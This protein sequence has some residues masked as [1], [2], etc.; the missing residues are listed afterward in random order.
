MRNSLQLLS[1]LIKRNETF[2]LS[3]TVKKFAKNEKITRI[4]LKMYNKLMHTSLGM[5]IRCVKQWQTLPKR[6]NP[7]LLRKCNKFQQTLQN[8]A[9][10][11][12][13]AGSMDS[14]K[15][16]WINGLTSKKSAAHTLINNT[17]S[18]Q[19]KCFLKWHN[20]AQNT[21]KILTCR[22]TIEFFDAIQNALSGKIGFTDILLNEGERELH[23]KISAMKKLI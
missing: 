11:S 2:K 7:E 5:A 14:L 13:R 23:I 3:E 20:F 12:I 1:S 18:S 17:M 10:K 9:V 6:K 16:D 22:K 15:D 19:K 21:R 8:L 4:M